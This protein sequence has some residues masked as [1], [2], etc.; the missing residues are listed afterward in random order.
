M[1][2]FFSGSGRVRKITK[3]PGFGLIPF[4]N[5]LPVLD[6]RNPDVASQCR[7]SIEFRAATPAE[8][9]QR[10]LDANEIFSD[11][12]RLES[13]I[14]WADGQVSF[15]ISQPQYHGEPAAAREIDHYFM[16]SGWTPIFDS[17]GHSIFFN[18]A[19]QLLAIDVE[20]RN[21]YINGGLLLPF[22]VLLCRPD[23][24]LEQYFRLYPDI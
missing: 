14:E 22:D 4:V 15:G 23:E 16:A 1:V 21:C 8:Y 9:L 6:L 19:W 20:S 24:A 7:Q 11:D 3:P 18:Y 10:W 5:S 2:D 13:V 12:V 17:S